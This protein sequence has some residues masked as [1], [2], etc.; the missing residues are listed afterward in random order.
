MKDRRSEA[1][2]AV[3]A[4]LAVLVALAGPAL[5]PGQIVWC[6]FLSGEK[7]AEYELQPDQE[8][9]VPLTPDQNPLRFLARLEYREPRSHFGRAETAFDG[10]LRQ[11]GQELWKKRFRVSHQEDDD[12]V[13]IALMSSYTTA[14]A[15]LFSIDEPGDF[16]FVAKST[17]HNDIDVRGITLKVRQNVSEVQTMSAVGGFALLI[18]AVVIAMVGARSSRRKSSEERVVDGVTQ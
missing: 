6:M 18:G 4:V 2:L 8:V 7:A 1:G 16:T 5:G 3:T 15:Q 10:V 9:V 14:A 12:E 13:G 11:G 17:R